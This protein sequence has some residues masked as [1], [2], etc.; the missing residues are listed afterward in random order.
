[1]TEITESAPESESEL[2]KLVQA[3]DMLISNLQS[4]RKGGHS[5]ELDQLANQVRLLNEEIVALR[6]E[7]IKERIE[8]E[9]LKTKNLEVKLEK[10]REVR[11]IFEAMVN[12][13]DNNEVLNYQ[14]SSLVRENKSLLALNE[15]LREEIKTYTAKRPEIVGSIQMLE[16][17]EKYKVLE[18]EI[19]YLRSQ[20]ELKD[21]QNKELLELVGKQ[22]LKLESPHL[23]LSSF[24]L[25]SSNL[26][27]THQSVQTDVIPL[28]KPIE[29][30]FSSQTE[31][32]NPF[33]STQTVKT[34]EIQAAF[35][36]EILSKKRLQKNQNLQCG[37]ER[38]L[39]LEKIRPSVVCK[40]IS[41]RLNVNYDLKIEKNKAINHKITQKREDIDEVVSKKDIDK[42]VKEIEIKEA[43]EKV[44]EI[45]NKAIPHE[46]NQDI[47][48]EIDIIESVA[49]NNLKIVAVLPVIVTKSN[50]IPDKSSKV[51]ETSYQNAQMYEAIS[52]D[53]DL[54]MNP[55]YKN[56]KSSEKISFF[57]ESL[58]QN[59]I[60]IENPLELTETKPDF[61]PKND[62]DAPPLNF[63][64]NPMKSAPINSTKDSSSIYVPRNYMKSDQKQTLS[65]T[66]LKSPFLAPLPKEERTPQK[67][68]ITESQDFKVPNPFDTKNP[69]TTNPWFDSKPQAL[70]T[71]EDAVS[72]FDKLVPKSN[73]SNPFSF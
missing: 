18:A 63:Y 9:D 1:M 2:A 64:T 53:E 42:G 11:G 14:T 15:R 70:D 31:F 43:V 41:S 73:F 35:K 21:D 57:E 25:D 7:L 6:N 24:D 5:E 27:L 71:A 58:D 8:C 28:D 29:I 23:N 17:K 44:Q 56:E 48:E 52:L 26:N 36:L 50:E 19:E 45:T 40:S 61:S 34:C 38:R 67:K 20:L 39:A 51:Q 62:P 30:D 3:Q 46:V 59:E 54:L 49:T 68:P 72:F 55:T 13:Q 47:M 4:L 37:R 65:S 69:V 22:N 60:F 16:M 12:L 66:H 32:P 10:R 33:K